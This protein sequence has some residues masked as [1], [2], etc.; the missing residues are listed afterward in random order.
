MVILIV[1]SLACCCRV[2]VVSQACLVGGEGL[3]DGGH[4][5]RGWVVCVELAQVM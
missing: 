2:S 1:L 3:E 4:Q 5:D